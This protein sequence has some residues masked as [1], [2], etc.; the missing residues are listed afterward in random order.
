ME[1]AL[2]LD[3]STFHVDTGDAQSWPW[4]VS[5]TWSSAAAS[6]SPGQTL[7]WQWLSAAAFPSLVRDQLPTVPSSALRPGMLNQH[8]VK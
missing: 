2:V 1:P 7:L 3:G 8:K 6:S 4:T 5:G